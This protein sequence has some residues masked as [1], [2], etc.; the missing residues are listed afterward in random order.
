MH[1]VTLAF[2]CCWYCWQLG[3]ATATGR[4]SESPLQD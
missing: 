4:A 1:T 3:W 2:Q